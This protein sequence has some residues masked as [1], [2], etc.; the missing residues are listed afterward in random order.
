MSF[1]QVIAA[2]DGSPQADDA[3]TL[4]LRLRDADDGVLTLA[5]V[6]SGRHWEAGAHV[7]RPDAVVPDEIAFVLD[8]ARDR[9]VPAGVRVVE[10]APVAP[11]AASGLTELATTVAADLI[12]VGSSQ[13]A[14]PGRV[15]LERTAGRLLEGAPCAVAVAP[16][17]LR[18][19]GPFRHVG[20]AYDGSPDART[21]LLAGYAIAAQSDAAVTVV[22][23]VREH[24]ARAD[25]QAILKT[26]VEAAPAGVAPRTVL[27]MGAPD[28]VVRGAC[29]GVVDLLV[30]GSRGH[31]ALQRALVGSVS[32]A[33]AEGSP[34]PVLVFPRRPAVVETGMRAALAPEAR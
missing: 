13:H 24:G 34:C 10:R 1:R 16:G 5:H 3:L 8:E 25:A 32:D 28:E 30:T 18:E 21:A 19:S 22:L 7:H 12:V 4:A 17:G 33:L 9:L 20:I 27:E 26:A 6:V 14:E 11:S 23:A 15:S 31:G 2:Y 29:D